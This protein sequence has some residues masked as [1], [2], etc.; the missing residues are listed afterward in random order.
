M[1]IGMTDEAK[2]NKLKKITEKKIDPYPYSYEGKED[3]SEIVSDFENREGK[4]AKIAGRIV[5]MRKMGSLFFMDILDGQGKMQAIARENYLEGKSIELLSLIDIGDIVGIFGTVTKSKR[6]EK[7]IDAKEITL[8][9]KSLRVLPEKFHGLKDIEIRYRKRYLDM[10]INPNVREYFKTR[11]RILRYMRNFLD[12]RGYIEFE[13]PVLQPVYG[14]ANAKPFKTYFNAIDSDVFLRISDEL[15]LKKLIVGGFEKVYEVSRDFRNED[16]DTTH[17]PE[18]TIIECYEAYKDYE[19]YMR[20]VEEMVG[21]IAKEILGSNIL[22]YQG[23]KLDFSTPFKR[24]YFVEELKRKTGID[25]SG[26]TDQEA[27]EIAAKEELKIKVK[28]RYHVA[29]GLFDK[30]IKSDLQD[31]TFVVDFPAYMCPLTKD[32]RGNG[33]L[34]ERFELYIAGY[35]EANSYSELTNPVE[36]RKKFMEQD[37]ERKKGDD[38][39]PPIDEDFLEAI[40]FGMPPTAGLGISIDRISMILTDNVSLKEVIAFPAARPEKNRDNGERPE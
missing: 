19:D 7:S 26:L 3:I 23:K 20:M 17:N 33:K 35:E 16:I 25:I 27:A 30:Y 37:A 8:L 36:Q 28:N 22:T 31:P 6:G 32:K 24:I 18:F 34:S 38:E 11:A 40:E 14:G 15:Y 13:T 5:G 10:I 39:A 21:G 12:S 1:L 9:S 4:D 29:D 2:L